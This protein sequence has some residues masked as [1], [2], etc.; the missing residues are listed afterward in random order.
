MQIQKTNLKPIQSLMAISLAISSTCAFSFELPSDWPQLKPGM[1]KTEMK[2]PG[3]KAINLAQYI[4][5]S[6]KARRLAHRRLST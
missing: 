2:M 4:P 3:M 1:F 5:L 6:A